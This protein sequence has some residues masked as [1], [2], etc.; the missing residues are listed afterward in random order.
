[1]EREGE[2]EVDEDNDGYGNKELFRSSSP[3]VKKKSLSQLRREKSKEGKRHLKN[4]R[5]SLSKKLWSAS[6]QMIQ[7][8]LK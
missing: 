8:L 3:D 5:L 1:M 4:P 7:K 6:L 2:E